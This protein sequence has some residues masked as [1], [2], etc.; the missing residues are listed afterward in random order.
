M[1]PHRSLHWQGLLRCGPLLGPATQNACH[2]CYPFEE[3]SVSD[4]GT[5]PVAEDVIGDA[6][7][8]PVTVMGDVFCNANTK[9]GTGDG[10]C[11]A[12]SEPVMEDVISDVQSDQWV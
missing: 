11:D 4:K 1:L 3:R 9:S 12:G 6:G 10:I 5:E 2:T 8:K 7:S